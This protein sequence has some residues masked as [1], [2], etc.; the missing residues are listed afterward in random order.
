LI[1]NVEVASMQLEVVK[2]LESG[3]QALKAMQSETSVDY[4]AQLLDEN[5]ELQAQVTEIGQMLSA[6]ESEDPDLYQEYQKLEALVALDK[7]S[8]LPHV[9]SSSV[10]EALTSI[11]ADNLTTRQDVMTSLASETDETPMEAAS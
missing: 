11:D 8:E 10:P 1:S 9:P 3:N 2:A 6:T 5:S 7:A 4:V